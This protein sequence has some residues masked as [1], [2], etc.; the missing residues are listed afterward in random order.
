MADPNF[1]AAVAM[2]N[3]APPEAAP[4]TDAPTEP[5]SAPTPAPAE[6][7]PAPTPEPVA[8]TPA[9]DEDAAL[10]EALEARKQARQA[11][12]APSEVAELRAQIAELKAKLEA[13]QPSAK[14]I[15][16]LIAEHGEIEGLR[17]AGLDPI[18]FFGKFK[19]RAKLNNPALQKLERETAEAKAVAEAAQRK[20]AER[21][22]TEAQRY[23]A[24]AKA[25]SEQVFLGVVKDPSLG[26]KL[27]PKMDPAQL[28]ERTYAKIDQLG[29]E[30]HDLSS[31]TDGELARL[32]ERDVRAEIQRLTGTDPGVTTTTPT[33]PATD[34]AKPRPDVPAPASLTNDLAAQST[35]RRELTNDKERFAAAVAILN[36]AQ[37]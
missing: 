26:L 4:A 35:G 10:L 33:V 15:K 8:P 6:A 1:E 22:Q 27:L 37:E 18:E 7:T 5:A 3:A 31:V 25:Q 34:G 24:H 13:P 2:L 19:E 12:Q 9:V 23:E 20:L 14:D 16:A 11:K 32:I 17:M 36:T 30:G 21:E 29:R 28:I